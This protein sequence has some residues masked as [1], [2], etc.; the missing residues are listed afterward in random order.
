MATDH[1]DIV[2][3]VGQKI[4]ITRMADHAQSEHFMLN[5]AIGPKAVV[6]PASSR[7]VLLAAHLIP[8]ELIELGI[9]RAGGIAHA[10]TRV[11]RWSPENRFLVII[12]PEHMAVRQQRSSYRVEARLAM[13]LVW[14]QDGS[15]VFGNGT[16]I[17]LSSG[18]SAVEFAAQRPEVGNEAVMVLDL[19]Q[20][21]PVTM[22]AQLIAVDEPYAGALRMSFSQLAATDRDRIGKQVQRIEMQRPRSKPR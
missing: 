2:T 9:A 11:E 10:V 16:T 19:G 22:V 12:N 8:G 17:N 14:M 20:P 18:G 21:P 6:A 7:A 5:S 4:R 13:R 3:L 15:P 1:V